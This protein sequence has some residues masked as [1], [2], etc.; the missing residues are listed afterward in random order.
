MLRQRPDTSVRFS[1]RLDDGT[2]IELELRVQGGRMRVAFAPTPEHAGNANTPR[3]VV[4]SAVLYVL[5]CLVGPGIPLNSGCLRPVEIITTPGTLTEP[6]PSR[7]VCSGNVETSQRIVDVLLGALGAAAASQGTMNN[8][9]FGDT[10][11]SYY[12][13]LAGGMGAGP[14]FDGASGVQVHM[15]N[16]RMTDPEVL[17][18]GYPVRLL[19]FRLLRGTGGAGKFHGGDGIERSL[20]FLAAVHVAIVSERRTSGPFGL[21]GGSPGARGANLLNGKPLAGR[22][23]FSARVG[24]VLNIRTPGGGGFGTP[25]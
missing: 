25:A 4:I 7:A 22:C 18:A 6:G 3:A 21:A 2:P 10:T 11:F 13:T 17:E 15:T 14:D 23:Q 20:E 9:T 16:T 24:D 1:D 5:R 8:L 12:E 19:S